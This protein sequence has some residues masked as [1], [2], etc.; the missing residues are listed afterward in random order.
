MPTVRAAPLPPE[1]R[2][3]AIIHAMIPLLGEHGRA[4][5]TKQIAAAAGVSEGTIF[6]VFADKDDLV[7]AAFDAAIDPAPFELA[8]A[9]IDPRL[10]F[11]EQVEAAAELSQR[12]IV[13]IWKLISAIGPHH[14]QKRGGPFPDSPALDALF[15]RFRGRLRVEPAEAARLLRALTLSLTHPMMTDHPR[16]PAEIVDLF[17]NGAATRRSRT[18]KGRP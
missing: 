2:R 6:N 10:P 18:T 3:L 11:E 12:R 14:H 17:L 15:D 16:T 1:E 13:H 9:A 5:T 4:V 8:V 7:Q